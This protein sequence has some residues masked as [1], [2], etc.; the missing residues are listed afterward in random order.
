MGTQ[1]APK[2]IFKP[3]IQNGKRYFDSYL[4]TTTK[5]Q[6]IVYSGAFGLEEYV[7]AQRVVFKRNPNYYAIDDNKN[8]LK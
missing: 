4:G 1:I 6:D 3:V 7:P 5:P 2:H 8:L